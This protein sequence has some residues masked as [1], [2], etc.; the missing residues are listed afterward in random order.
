M[1]KNPHSGNLRNESIFL[2]E[3]GS[4]E[5]PLLTS[6]KVFH[7]C[8]TERYKFTRKANL[9]DSHVSMA[10]FRYTLNIRKVLVETHPLKDKE[11]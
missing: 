7:F 3:S 2:I 4:C 11:K 8:K 9:D 1:V 6:S 5:P 10:S